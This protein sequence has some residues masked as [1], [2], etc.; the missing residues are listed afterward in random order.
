MYKLDPKDLTR[1]SER[2]ADG[3]RFVRYVHNPTGVFVE[4]Y[5]SQDEPIPMFNN[6]L[7]DE[8]ESRVAAC[9]FG[10]II[11]KDCAQE[12]TDVRDPIDTGGRAS[13]PRG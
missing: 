5:S 4:S 3:R 8:L 1:I 9:K 11:R 6:H 7:L 12:L 10:P 2:L 13:S